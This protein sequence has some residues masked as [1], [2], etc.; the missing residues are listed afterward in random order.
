M[1]PKW[2]EQVSNLIKSTPI[3]T[4]QDLLHDQTMLLC[5]I[6]KIKLSNA[7]K[8]FSWKYMCTVPCSLAEKA[9]AVT[10][11]EKHSRCHIQA[12]MTLDKAIHFIKGFKPSLPYD[13]QTTVPSQHLIVQ[14][15]HRNVHWIGAIG[16]SK[17]QQNPAPTIQT[18]KK[19]TDCSFLGDKVPN[20]EP[21]GVATHE[22]LV[23]GKTFEGGV[24]SNEDGVG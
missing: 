21:H 20:R 1:S 2:K 7:I 15:Q 3:A 12:W 10:S 22:A 19:I 18:R 13:T 17:H 14:I 6:R 16:A 24:E 4:K 11:F 9:N 8:S 5:C 23:P